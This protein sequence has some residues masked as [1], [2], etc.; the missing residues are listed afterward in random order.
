MVQNKMLAIKEMLDKHCKKMGDYS[1]TLLNGSIQRLQTIY[2][3]C[4]EEHNQ[5]LQKVCDEL[6]PPNTQ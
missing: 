1:A 4:C 2:D 5:E 3:N 6:F